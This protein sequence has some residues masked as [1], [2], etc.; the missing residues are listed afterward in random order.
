MLSRNEDRRHLRPGMAIVGALLA[1][2]A[3]TAAAQSQ[4]ATDARFQPWIGCWRTMDS[5]IGLEELGSEQQP[6]RACVVPSTSAPGTVDIVLFNRDSLLSRNTVPLPGTTRNKVIDDCS[7]TETAMWT[8]SESRLMLKAELTCTQGVKRSETGLM[9]LSAAGQWLQLQ[10]M[11][12]GKNE[13]TTVSRLRFEGDSVAPTG[14]SLGAVRSTRALRLAYGSPITT[15]ELVAVSTQVPAGLAQAW[16]AESGQRFTVDAKALVAMA[17]RK[18]P[19]PVI[20]VVIAL[21]N[22]QRFRVGPAPMEERL[23]TQTADITQVRSA[24]NSRCSAIDSFCYGAGGMGAWGLGWRYGM[25]DPWGWGMSPYGIGYGNRFGYG[26]GG[27]GWN[28]WGGPWGLGWGGGYN[29]GIYYGGGPVIIPSNP[30]GGGGDGSVRGRAVNGGGYTRA[31]SSQG[32]SSTFWPAP[33]MGTSGS[34]S[35]ASTGSAGGAS[36]G[37]GGSTGRTAVPRPPL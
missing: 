26:Y 32:P 36:S 10:H 12:V 9:S 25:F 24:R 3:T 29:G 11:V 19:S 35:G 23:M 1:L 7:G 20:D 18:V 34:G 2:S 13:A 5:G 22:P 28:Q 8:P 17:D 30:G 21:A 33:S 37:G 16:L 4:A 15:E 6:T 14:L 31:S 27:L